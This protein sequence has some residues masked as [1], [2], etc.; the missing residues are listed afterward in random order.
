MPKPNIE[1]L[2][3]KIQNKSE[4]EAE[5]M[6]Y[7]VIVEENPMNWW[8]GEKEDGMFVSLEDFIKDLEQLKN[9][10][11]ITIR[12][13]SCGG[14]FN[15]GVVIHNLL[16]ELTAHKIGIIDGLAASAMSIILCA[17][18]EIH[19]FP[20]SRFMI[21]E[22]QA[23]ICGWFNEGD[24]QKFINNLASCKTSMTQIYK[25]KSKKTEDEIVDLT[26]AE[27]WFVGQEIIDN[28]FADKLIEGSDVKMKVENNGKILVANGVKHDISAYKNFKNIDIESNSF[29]SFV[30][31]V[32]DK[33]ISALKIESPTNESEIKTEIKTEQPKE[34]EETM[35]NTVEELKAQHPD[36]VAK[37]VEETTQSVK[38]EASIAE[39]ERIKSIESIEASIGDKEL[40]SKAKYGEVNEICSA[41]DLALKAMQSQSG[42]GTKYLDQIDADGKGTEKIEA[43]ANSGNESGKNDEQD[44]VAVLNA[45]FDS[46]KNGG[47][48]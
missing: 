42:L 2:K 14:D 45:A 10:E 6:F 30:D 20:G 1:M 3:W 41:S 23:G 26:K 18:D 9:K 17:C 5:L 37:I 43:S 33:V 35:C 7:G 36:L 8:T 27:T 34:R 39:R 4:N 48:Q 29:D 12:V 40:I 46:V 22:A 25:N 15:T 13:N 38:T 44:A 31:K 47:E 28:G 16:K 32:K 24:L 19:V 11:T 21:H